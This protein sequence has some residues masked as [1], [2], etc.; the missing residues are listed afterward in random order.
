MGDQFSICFFKRL[1]EIVFGFAM[2]NPFT[3][4]VVKAIA[5]L[6]ELIC[7]FACNAA[8]IVQ[9]FVVIELDELVCLVQPVRHVDNFT[10]FG[11]V[12][13]VVEESGYEEI[14]PPQ[15]II[16]EVVFRC[17]DVTFAYDPAFPVGQA[18]IVSR[19]VAAGGDDLGGSIAGDGVVELVLDLREKVVGALTVGIIIVRKGNDVAQL[20]VESRFVRLPSFSGHPTCTD[21]VS[22]GE[23]VHCESTTQEVHAG[24]PA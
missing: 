4:R 15:F 18:E 3:S 6:S 5:V 9:W 10:T 2:L 24:V 21:V 16:S 23:D 8:V 7:V 20:E 19:W 11:L 22:V 14:K 17:R 13:G 1:D 12:L